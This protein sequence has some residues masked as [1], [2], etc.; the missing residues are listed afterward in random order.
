MVLEN[1]SDLIEI[2]S[3]KIQ[4]AILDKIS[5]ILICEKIRKEITLK[6][7]F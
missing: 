3:G 6:N 7:A 1:S 2:F 5:Y 4:A